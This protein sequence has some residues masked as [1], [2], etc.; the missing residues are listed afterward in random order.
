MTSTLNVKFGIEL[1]TMILVPPPLVPPPARIKPSN[2]W[3]DKDKEEEIRKGLAIYLS[4]YK[5][6]IYKVRYTNDGGDLLNSEGQR[7]TDDLTYWVVCHDGSVYY[8]DANQVWMN[9]D[10]KGLRVLPIPDLP[11]TSIY[12]LEIDGENKRFLLTDTIGSM[13]K[14]Q[15]RPINHIE[16]VSPVLGLGEYSQIN[17]IFE[18]LTKQKQEPPQPMFFHNATTSTHIHMSIWNGNDNVFMEPMNIL[19]ICCAWLAFEDF[20]FSLVAPWRNSREYCLRMEQL[21]EIDIDYRHDVENFVIKRD[22]IED[23]FNSDSEED[24]ED[25]K[26]FMQELLHE[27]VMEFQGDTRYAALNLHNLVH[28]GKEPIGTI[29]CRILHGTTDKDE[30]IK[31]VELL[32]AFFQAAMKKDINVLVAI[33]AETQNDNLK[34]KTL[35]FIK[36]LDI[37]DVPNA[38]KIR[39]ITSFI[40]RQQGIQNYYIPGASE[41]K[42]R[43]GN[44]GKPKIN[45]KTPK[46]QNIK[47]PF[48]K[49]T[50]RYVGEDKVPRVI[51]VKGKTEYTKRK[52]IDGFKY[53]RTPV[54]SKNGNS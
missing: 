33:Y 14:I 42:K 45:A 16:I 36:F 1:E 29:E 11:Y 28:T 13:L 38:D 17:N 10:D 3:F 30:I 6:E 7:C 22:Y 54:L 47:T 12:S 37:Q 20:F 25:K 26:Q 46:R 49:T 15:W 19:K 41:I 5:K 44:L 8:T 9:T 18:Q 27:I 32:S 53:V 48:I 23:T 51:F 4:K 21:I 31:F 40:S 52:S 43:G 2:V 39:Y 24:K 34:A 50:R 35:T